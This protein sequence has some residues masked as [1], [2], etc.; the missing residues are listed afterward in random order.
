[1]KA[2]LDASARGKGIWGRGSEQMDFPL[3]GK[4]MCNDSSY[5]LNGG[6]FVFLDLF[7]YVLSIIGKN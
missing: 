6:F 3:N 1:M 2:L 4:K 5:N 7:Q